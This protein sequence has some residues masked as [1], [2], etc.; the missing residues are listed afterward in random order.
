MHNI[1][2]AQGIKRSG[3]CTET[4]KYFAENSHSSTKQRKMMI[5]ILFLLTISALYSVVAHP[6]PGV[7]ASSPCAEHPPA[8]SY[9]IHTLFW[10]NNQNSTNAAIQLQDDF[11]KQFNIS[12]ESNTCPFEPGNEIP[13][14]PLCVFTTD[15]KPAGPFLTAQTA[16]YIPLSDYERSI[17]WIVPRRGVLDIF[18]HPNSGCSVKDHVKDGLWAGNKWELDPTIFFD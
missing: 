10:Q 8:Q 12:R 14:Y 2:F 3:F 5:L 1:K 17:N 18:V 4:P 15:F 9:H 6:Q 16:L 11:L 7:K 13:D